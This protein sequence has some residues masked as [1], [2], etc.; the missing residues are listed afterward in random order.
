MAITIRIPQN[1]AVRIVDKIKNIPGGEW[2]PTAIERLNIQPDG[3]IL[4]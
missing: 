3:S 4:V 1:Y 2:D